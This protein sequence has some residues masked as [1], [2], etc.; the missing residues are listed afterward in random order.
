MTIGELIRLLE[1][2]PP[3][4]RVVVDGYEDGWDDLSP[5]Q[6]AVAKIRLHAGVRSWEGRHGDPRDPSKGSRNCGDV[7]DALVL[8]RSSN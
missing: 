5:E 2:H 4:L 8:G 7:V 3:G 6:I 1:E